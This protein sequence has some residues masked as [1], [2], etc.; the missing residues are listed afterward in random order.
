M[1]TAAPDLTS[2]LSDIDQLL[3]EACERYQVPGATLA[4]RQGDQLLEYASG[5]VNQATGVEATP[6]ALFQIGSITKLFTTTLM[7]QLVDDG[8]VDLDTPVRTYL[9]E[10]NLQ[11]Q[12]QAA[13]VTVRQ[14]L[15]HI[16]GIDGDFFIDTGRGDDC[17]ERYILALAGVPKLHEPGQMWS[18]CNAAFSIAGRIIEKQTALTWDNALKQRLLRPAGIFTMG[19]LPEEAILG[20]AAAGH[21]PNPEGGWRVAP[22]WALPRSNGPAGAT[23]F[24]AARDLLTFGWMHLRGGRTED[25][26][27]ILSFESVRHMQEKQADLPGVGEPFAWGLGWMLFDWGGQRIIGHDGGTV[28]QSSFFRMAPEKQF[29]AAMLTNGGNTQALYRK[30]I[31]EVFRRG[32]DLEMPPLPQADASITVDPSRFVG[33]YEKLSA[34]LEIALEDGNLTATSIS[35][36]P[37]ENPPVVYDLAPINDTNLEVTARQTRFRGVLTFLNPRPDGTFDYVRSGSRLHRRTP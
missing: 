22:I 18:Y 3:H 6:D 13:A 24:A 27:R 37:L 20:R 15:C 29:G 34:R 4:I 11:D 30:V 10:F 28:G 26:T 33:A 1:T 17:V 19:T 31:G 35:T 12:A 7:M 23:P 25:G 32:A 16:S 14:L 21:V 9:P 2:R 5:V 8:R 36:G